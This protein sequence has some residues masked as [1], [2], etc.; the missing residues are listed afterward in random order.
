MREMAELGLCF[1]NAQKELADRHASDG[2]LLYVE[3]Y[4][5]FESGRFAHH[6]WLKKDGKILEVSPE[7][8][9]G[10][11]VHYEGIEFTWSQVIKRKMELVKNGGDGRHL[12]SIGRPILIEGKEIGKGS[13]LWQKIRPFV[14]SQ[15]N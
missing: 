7:T 11:R 3:G 15:E 8:E 14:G 12:T 6:A 13:P 5:V 2:K 1:W 9:N 10:K 4:V